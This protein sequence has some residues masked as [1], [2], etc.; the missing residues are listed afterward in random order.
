MTRYS[1]EVNVNAG[2]YTS[3]TRVTCNHL[4]VCADGVSVVADG[5][6]ISF[7]EGIVSI[8][9]EGVVP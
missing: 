2:E 5:V 6:E 9:D 7:D 3:H 4:T 1:I 8:E